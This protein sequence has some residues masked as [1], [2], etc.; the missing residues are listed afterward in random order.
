MMD[1]LMEQVERAVQA[2]KVYKITIGKKTAEDVLE[3][4]Q[5][6][7]DVIATNRENMRSKNMKVMQFGGMEGSVYEANIKE[8]NAKIS[9]DKKEVV[10]D[11]KEMIEEMYNSKLKTKLL[12]VLAKLNEEECL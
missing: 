7:A 6:Y 2:G 8:I 10:S 9:E 12:N 11:L 4:L 1:A 3:T 5:E